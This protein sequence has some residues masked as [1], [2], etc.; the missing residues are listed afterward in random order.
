[1]VDKLLLWSSGIRE[2]FFPG[3]VLKLLSLLLLCDIGDANKEMS[4]VGEPKILRQNTN[5]PSA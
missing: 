2:G 5:P 4:C 1:M 3:S